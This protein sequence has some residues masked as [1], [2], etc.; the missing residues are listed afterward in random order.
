MASTRL[1]TQRLKPLRRGSKS[2]STAGTQLLSPEDLELRPRTAGALLDQT[3]SVYA[4]L[5]GPLVGFAVL[6]YVPLHM[7][8]D[9]YLGPRFQR[10]GLEAGLGLLR[11]L[12][13]AALTTGF[14]SITLGGLFLRRQVSQASAVGFSL[15]SAPGVFSLY[16][17][18]IV[19]TL[20]A[21]CLFVVPGA[22]FAWLFSVAAA[23]YVLEGAAQLGR[24]RDQ[25][26]GKFPL[27]R[28][29][30]ALT[31]SRRLTWGWNSLGRFV[32]AGGAALLLIY[33]PMLGL[34]TLK[35]SPELRAT[36]LSSGWL[37]S[38]LADFAMLLVSSV[39][40]AAG[41][42]FFDVF[43]TLYYLDLCVRREAL[44]L[45]VELERLE[46]AAG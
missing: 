1:I 10:Q 41:L 26:G 46:E 33:L 20:A 16:F 28:V 23:A 22:M 2:P 43:F 29:L 13:P 39:S 11:D 37:S 21:C 32:A 30:Q 31:R 15:R 40:T 3:F 7:L 14:V 34:N 35:E 17:V 25:W 27:W 19:I 24:A 12:L 9:A 44:D 5:F 42:V 4:R 45:E 36:L 38:S 18:R 6:A 8:F